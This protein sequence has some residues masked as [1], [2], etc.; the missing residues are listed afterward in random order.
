[1]ALG[2]K[3]KPAG[4]SVVFA[5]DDKTARVNEECR[6]SSKSPSLVRAGEE[7]GARK[8]TRLDASI[9]IWDNIFKN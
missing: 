2:D 9:P 6:V 1:M 3:K 5:D 7:E 8:L 4:F